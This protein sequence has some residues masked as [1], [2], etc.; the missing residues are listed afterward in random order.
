MLP[1]P[2][3]RIWNHSIKFDHVINWQNLRLVLPDWRVTWISLLEKVF[4]VFYFP[5]TTVV[6][7]KNLV[8][9]FGK[10]FFLILR[11]QFLFKSWVG[12]ETRLKKLREVWNY[13]K[14]ICNTFSWDTVKIGII[15][16]AK[17]QFS[18]WFKM[19][20]CSRVSSICTGLVSLLLVKCRQGLSNCIKNPHCFV[21][22]SFYV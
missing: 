22:V 2:G 4:Q 3:L 11:S 14:F 1:I 15:I 8:G 21:S 7:T 10:F 5:S 12:N 6:K 13:G 17:V 9:I 20:G 19:M 16:R 18:V